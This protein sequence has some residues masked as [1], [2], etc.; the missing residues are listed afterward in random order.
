[1]TSARSFK[2]SVNKQIQSK[3]L[4]VNMLRSMNM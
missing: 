2:T 4:V 3:G 1:M